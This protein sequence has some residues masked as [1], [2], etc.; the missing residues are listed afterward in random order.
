MPVSNV[1]T[2]GTTV[3]PSA[4]KRGLPALLGDETWIIFVTPSPGHTVVRIG[5]IMFLRNGDGPVVATPLHHS[6][7]F[8]RP[9]RVD[10]GACRRGVPS[11]PGRVEFREPAKPLNLVSELRHYPGVCITKSMHY[12]METPC[13]ANSLCT[14]KSNTTWVL[15]KT[16]PP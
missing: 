5:P 14:E 6:A 16:M 1:P 12:P 7:P 3:I 10:D 8:R 2:M 15:T 11:G 9:L 4:A 13:K